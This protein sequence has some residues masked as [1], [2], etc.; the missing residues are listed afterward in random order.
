MEY[1]KLLAGQCS[2]FTHGL[3]MIFLMDYSW[4]THGLLAGQC[5]WVSSKILSR[6][7]ECVGCCVKLLL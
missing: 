1:Y 3:F 5:S 4:I 2:W 6:C 7:H